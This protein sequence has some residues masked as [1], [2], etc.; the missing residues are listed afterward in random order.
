VS[1]GGRYYGG[2]WSVTIF[3]R[4]YSQYNGVP[5]DSYPIRIARSSIGLVKDTAWDGEKAQAAVEGDFLV[6]Y[7]F[8]NHHALEDPVAQASFAFS[9]VGPRT[10]LMVD[11]EPNRGYCATVADAW[12]FI[13]QYRALG[14]IV[15]L[16]YCPH[17]SWSGNLGSP[18]LSGFLA[19]GLHLVSSDY[20]TY[21]DSGPGWVGYGNVPVNQWQFT[22]S[23]YDTNAFKGTV[24][25]YENLVAPELFGV[26]TSY[27]ED[28][29]M[30]DRLETVGEETTFMPASVSSGKACFVGLTTGGHGGVPATVNAQLYYDGGWHNLGTLTV[31]D[32]PETL[33]PK[34]DRTN[35]RNVYIKLLTGPPVSV[36]CVPDIANT[37]P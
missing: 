35:V 32:G 2:V 30:H 6:A 21:S 9:I 23:P 5:A 25:D 36:S 28:L 16:Y 27:S 8:L 34:I 3:F 14:G 7:H 22:D 18:D 4:D 33:L 26:S 29:E 37:T 17:W 31:N 15:H 12:A 19:A 20:T 13:N 10:P 24:L 11:W 1:E